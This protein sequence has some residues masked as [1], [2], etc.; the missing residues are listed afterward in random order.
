MATLM[1]SPKTTDFRGK[2]LVHVLPWLHI[3]PWQR[4]SFL[5]FH[6]CHS[7]IG[8]MVISAPLKR[9]LSIPDASINPC[10]D[11]VCFISCF[12][13]LPILENNLNWNQPHAISAHRLS[14]LGI[15]MF[16]QGRSSSAQCIEFHGKVTHRTRRT[17]E[18]WIWYWDS[19]KETGLAVGEPVVG[20][21]N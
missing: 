11:F 15:S 16:R 13:M 21:V 5:S 12:N 9:H 1:D 2:W 4:L 17:S 7:F 10:I 3:S 18:L 6:L 20:W 14:C 19:L 8:A